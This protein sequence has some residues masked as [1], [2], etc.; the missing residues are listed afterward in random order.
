MPYDFTYMWNLKSKIN[1]Q[2][3]KNLID[4]ENKLM[5]ARREGSCK[6]WHV[7]IQYDTMY[8]PQHHHYI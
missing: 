7:L 8:N 4:T 3:R 1:K 5:V 6:W 2:N